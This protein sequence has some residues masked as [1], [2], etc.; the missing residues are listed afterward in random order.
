MLSRHF[1]RS[2]VLQQ[3]YAT[4]IDPVDITIAER[5]FKHNISRLNDLGTIQIAAL[6]H[7]VET[8]GQIIDEA[9]HKYLPTEEERNPNRRLPCN[10][11]ISRLADNYDLRHHI[12]ESHVNWSGVEYDEAFHQAY[13]AVTRMSEYTNYLASEQ[14]FANDQQFALKVFKYLMNQEALRD[15]IQSQSL[16]WEDD[17]D[18]I[19]QYNFMMLKSLGDTLDEATPI[20]LMNDERYEKDADAYEFARHL[21]LVTLRHSDEVEAM[22]RKN[23]RGWDFDRVASMDV[24]L[25]NMA[26]AEL[27]EFPSIPE[28]VTV[29]EYIEL[30]KEFSTERSRLF[31]NG[32]ID[33]FIIELRSA[34]RINKTGRGLIDPSLLDDLNENEYPTE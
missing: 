6:V 15:L 20:P 23:L 11:F 19:A 18:Q 17:Y 8:A 14:T 33:K 32:I 13:T 31:I 4:K 28:G 27:T 22:I 9:Q 1:L 29:D 24:L 12:E 30:S 21:L 7:F 25:L 10:L 5:N 26:V 34:G 3:V 2:K 16:L